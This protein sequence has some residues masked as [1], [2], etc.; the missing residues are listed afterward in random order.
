MRN[1]KGRLYVAPAATLQAEFKAYAGLY[2]GAPISGSPAYELLWLYK[3]MEALWNRRARLAEEAR[4]NG[5]EPTARRFEELGCAPETATS[6]CHYW[7][8]KEPGP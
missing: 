6:D 7:S 4:E 1:V 5:I 2:R 3:I 8:A